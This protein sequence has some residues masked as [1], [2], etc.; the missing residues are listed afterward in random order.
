MD[1]KEAERLL[2]DQVHRLEK[3]SRSE[4]VA[5][6]GLDE[7]DTREVHG[8]SGTSYQLETELF[9]E[10]RSHTDLR[11]SISIDDGGWRAFFPLT[12]G[13]TVSPSDQ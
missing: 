1:R 10:N 5:Q 4:I 7:P 6:V 3:L 8:P 12:Y 11:V 13:F 2:L 9:W